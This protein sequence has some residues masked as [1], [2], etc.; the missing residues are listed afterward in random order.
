MSES[1]LRS[2]Q[3]GGRALRSDAE[4]NRQRI[5]AAAGEVFAEQGVEASL[6]EVARRAGVGEATL[7]RR[8]P[9][10][11]ELLAEV[12]AEKMARYADA[13]EASLT[14]DDPWQ[15]F[16]DF[17]EEAVRMQARD[18]GFNRVMLLSFPGAHRFEE[19]RQRVNQ[20]FLELVRRAREAGRLRSDFAPQDLGLLLMA[21]AGLTVAAGD[22]APEASH[23]L[24]AY[25][26]QAFEAPGT[27]PL[28]PPPPEGALREAMRKYLE[29]K[30]GTQR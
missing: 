22:H 1:A 7:F 13:L 5:L 9:T 17:V 21:N 8:F 27:E 6:A 14:R 20:G 15:G 3:A 29:R 4:A 12:F 23:R 24:T 11:D 28:P 26:L 10:R 19:E 30:C 18:L 25:L 2:A 16:R